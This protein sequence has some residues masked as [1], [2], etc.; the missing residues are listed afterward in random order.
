MYDWDKMGIKDE[1]DFWFLAVIRDFY[2]WLFS[3]FGGLRGVVLWAILGYG[4]GKRNRIVRFR[5]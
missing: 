3:S 1:S 2:L 5:C 4:L